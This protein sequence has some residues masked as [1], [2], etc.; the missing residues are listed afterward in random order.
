MLIRPLELNQG[1][2]YREGRVDCTTTVK[3][4]WKVYIMERDGTILQLSMKTAE[5]VSSFSPFKRDF[6]ELIVL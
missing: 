1:S 5:V 4:A 2:L 3:L 6:P